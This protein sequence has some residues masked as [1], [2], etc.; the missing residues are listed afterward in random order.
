MEQSAARG[1]KMG[2]LDIKG[3]S[4][5]IMWFIE[6]ACIILLHFK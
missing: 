1:E 6:A 5:R 4:E 3:I 2:G